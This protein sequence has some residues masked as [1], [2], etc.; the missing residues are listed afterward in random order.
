MPIKKKTTNKGNNLYGVTP[1]YIESPYTDNKAHRAYELNASVVTIDGILFDSDEKSMDRIN[2]LIDIA[3]FKFNKAIHDG[4]TTT[5]AYQAMYIDYQIPW[6]THDNQF[7]IVSI[8]TLATV[9]EQ[10]LN[11]MSAL[12][13]KWG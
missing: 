3:N 6:K 4:A 12:W 8:D 5:D 11:E 13:A 9:Q 7:V 10:A 2:R 1:V